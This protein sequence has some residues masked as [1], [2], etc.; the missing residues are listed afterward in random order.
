MD[1]SKYIK[2]TTPIDKKQ[3]AKL[4]AGDK[5]L[6]TGTI[7][8]ARDAAHKTFGELP[9][10]EAKGAIIYYASPTPTKKG[11]VIGSIGPTTSSRMDTFT[12]ALLKAG[13]KITIGK[14]NRSTEVIEAIKKYKAA[15]LVVPGGAAA[16]MAKHIKRSAIIAYPDL[17]SEAV[18]EL[19]VHDFPATVA[20]DSKGHNLFTHT[21]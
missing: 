10:F 14:G 3:V 2:L 7:Y 8:T 4:S 9:P 20:I 11:A 21:K 6:I 18:H 17:Q 12:P 15:Y 16:L 1:K 13:I 5:V 19:D